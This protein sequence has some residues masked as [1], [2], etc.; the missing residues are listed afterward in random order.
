MLDICLKSHIVPQST[1]LL[2]ITCHEYK[3]AIMQS[4]C[5]WYQILHTVQP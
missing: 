1:K 4:H 2:I 5:S 3:Y